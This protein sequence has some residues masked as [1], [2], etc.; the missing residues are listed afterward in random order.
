MH[1]APPPVAAV[2]ANY[3]QSGE[4]DHEVHRSGDEI[5]E[6]VVATARRMARGAARRGWGDPADLESAA[7][8]GV[9]LAYHRHRE[10]GNDGAPPYGQVITYIR[11]QVI[12]ARLAHFRRSARRPACRGGDSP[13]PVAQAEAREFWRVAFSDLTER[14]AAAF[15]LVFRV[16]MNGAEAARRMG[17]ST[18]RVAFILREEQATV[19]AS[20]LRGYKGRPS[21]L[22]GGAV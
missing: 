3:E 16:G 12:K 2:H 15:D 1:Y 7:M 19:R 20:L 22:K 21:E 9:A 13:D 6:A 10:A 4:A 14:Q 11:F 17:I 18:Q 8:F 5:P